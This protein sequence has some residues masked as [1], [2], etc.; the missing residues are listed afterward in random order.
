MVR[1]LMLMDA[2]LSLPYNLAHPACDTNPRAAITF[3]VIKE[4]SAMTATPTGQG[5]L[6]PVVRLLLACGAL[7]PMLFIVVFL[8]EGATRPDYNAS[9]YPVSSLSIGPYGWVQAANF[10]LVGATLIA[11]AV[12]MRR[13]LKGSRG[14]VWGPL[15]IGVAGVGLLGAGVFTTDPIYGYPPSAPLVLAQYTVHGHLHDAV[16]ALVFVG[17][18]AACFV[19]TRRFVAT[20]ERGWA[21]YSLLAGLGM[22][23]AFVLAGVGFEQN[24]VLV[25]VAGVFQRLSIAIGFTWIAVLAIRFL[26]K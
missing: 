12:G 4:P 9:R 3:S 14:G 23:V 13:A 17:I 15:L 25:S 18:P 10:L 20:H 19:F 1:W 16:S 5:A 21:V 8:I 11:G 2:L 26:R 22:L 24:A 7:G 6:S